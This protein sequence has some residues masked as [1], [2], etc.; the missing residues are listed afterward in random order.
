MDDFIDYSDA[1]VELDGLALEGNFG[2][3]IA[4]RVSQRD[5]T[6]RNQYLYDCFMDIFTTK[7]YGI[8]NIIGISLTL[9][10]LFTDALKAESQEPVDVLAAFWKGTKEHPELETV[11]SYTQYLSAHTNFKNINAQYAGKPN[12]TRAEIKKLADSVLASYSKGVEFIGK[13]FT[14]LLTLEQIIHSQPHDYFENSFLRIYEKINQYESLADESHK[15]LTT[16]I[17]RKVRNADAHLNAYYSI[18]KQS[19]VMKQTIN[20]KKGK[21]E[22]KTFQISAKEMM[23]EIYPRIGW[24]VQGFMGACVLLVLVYE[25]KALYR[26]ATD[27]ILALNNRTNIL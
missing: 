8:K 11:S 19:Y 6:E 1:V 13:A 15:K 26:K 21:K 10:S 22:I 2:S 14:S 23:L 17:N 16:I 7:Q 25:D 18:E 20:K 12:P 9:V 24:F 3:D 5:T 27:F 4:V